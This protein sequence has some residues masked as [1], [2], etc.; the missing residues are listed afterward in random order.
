MYQDS[1][2]GW[3]Q[4][5]YEAYLDGQDNYWGEDEDEYNRDLMLEQ[6][7]LEDYDET[8]EAYGCYGYDDGYDGYYE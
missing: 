5:E 7:E 2:E 3:A 4:D 6:Q 1:R 8:D